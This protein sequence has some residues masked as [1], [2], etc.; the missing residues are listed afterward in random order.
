MIDVPKKSANREPT[1]IN[2]LSKGRMP[3]SISILSARGPPE[4]GLETKSN[5][6]N[7]APR[8]ARAKITAKYFLISSPFLRTFPTF[9][10]FSPRSPVPP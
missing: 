1:R 5:R 2:A 4:I 10:S 3:S 8:T 9:L 7:K 6:L